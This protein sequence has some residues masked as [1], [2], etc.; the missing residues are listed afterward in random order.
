MVGG[1][2]FSLDRT[3]R[4]SGLCLALCTEREE[5]VGAV[6]GQEDTMG[7]FS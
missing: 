1:D 6:E 2:D 3:V 4:D 5:T 7:C